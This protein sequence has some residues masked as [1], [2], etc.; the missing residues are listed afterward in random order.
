MVVD[1]S[2]TVVVP[3]SEGDGEGEETL[4]FSPHDNDNI[5]APIEAGVVPLGQAVRLEPEDLPSEHSRRFLRRRKAIQRMPYS[6]ERIKHKQLLQGYDM[7]GFESISEELKLPRPNPDLLGSFQDTKIPTDL[8]RRRNDKGHHDE[9]DVVTEPIIGPVSEDE[10]SEAEEEERQEQ[11]DEVEEEEGEEDNEEELVKFRGRL[12]NIKTGFRG[13]LPRVAWE[14]AIKQHNSTTRN[15]KR[16]RDSAS[17]NHRGVAKKKNVATEKNVNQDD[18]LLNDLIVPD[19][20]VPLDDQI[21]LPL[22]KTNQQEVHDL[23]QLDQQYQKKYDHQYLSDYED[24]VEED[25]MD[26]FIIELGEVQNKNQVEIAPTFVLTPQ[27]TFNQDDDDPD[28]MEVGAVENDEGAIDGMLSKGPRIKGQGKFKSSTKRLGDTTR[29]GS[30]RKP[31]SYRMT[32]QRRSVR[33]PNRGNQQR[34]KQQTRLPSNYLP[35]QNSLKEAESSNLKPTSTQKKHNDKAKNKKQNSETI[36]PFAPLGSTNTRRANVFST[37]MEAPSDK[38]A[39]PKHGISK[40]ESSDLII[41][42]NTN[43]D[44]REEAPLSALKSLFDEKQVIPPDTISLNLPDRQFVLS[45]FHRND[46]PL[47]LSNIFDH[48]TER[49][50]TDKELL[51]ISESVTLFL[52][53]FNHLGVLPVISEFH[54]RF[55]S[56]VSL[57]REKAKSIHFYQIAVCQLMLLEVSKYSDISNASRV[58]LNSSILNHIISF[59]KL[60]SYCYDAVAKSDP[61]YLFQSFDILSKIAKMLN[62]YDT[63]WDKL[64]EQGFRPEVCSFLIDSFHTNNPHWEILKIEQDY[65]SI[66]EAF[67]FVNHCKR[68]YNWKITKNLIF[69]FDKIFKRRRFEDFTNECALTSGYILKPSQALRNNTMF[70]NYLNLLQEIELSDLVVERI[71]PMG[72]LSPNDSVAALINRLNLLMV[73]ARGSHVNL[74]KRM[75][76]LLRPLLDSEYLSKQDHQSLKKI[77]QLVLDGILSLADINR[78]KN[79]PFRGKILVMTFKNLLF[80]CGETLE[81]AWTNFL[82]QLIP[83]IERSTK[84]KLLFC[85][86]FYPCLILMSQRDIFTENLVQVLQL[87]LRNLSL[88]GAKWAQRNILQ[89]VKNKVDLSANWIDYY[90][91]VGKFLIQSNVMSWWSFYMYNDV[92]NSLTNKFY[93]DCKILQMCD[94]QSFELIKKSM[95]T[96]A[97]NSILQISSTWFRRFLIQL[98]N[99]ECSIIIDHRYNKSSNDTLNIAKRFVW[100]LNRL[101]YNDLLLQFI[102]NLKNCHQKKVVSI[103]FVTQMLEYLNLKFID[104]IK[105]SHDFFSLKRELGISDIETEK[106]AFRDAF[107]SQKDPISQASF[108]EWGLIHAH[109]NEEEM[110]RYMDKLESLFN[111]SAPEGSFRFFIRLITVHLRGYFLHCKRRLLIYFLYL[112]NGVLNARHLQISNSEFLELCMLH[113]ILC[114]PNDVMNNAIVT[115]DPSSQKNLRAEYLQFQFNVLRIADG[116]LEFELLAQ[117]SRKFLSGS[118]WSGELLYEELFDIELSNK[119][120]DIFRYNSLTEQLDHVYIL[121]DLNEEELE[122]SISE[123]IKDTPPQ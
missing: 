95:F 4:I 68:R 65:T 40:S 106:S 62:Q 75:E 37:V 90:C 100:M 67:R 69:L 123:L 18:S 108:V 6:L 27:D 31:S 16:R 7:S 23:K 74:E 13:V 87:Y 98:M 70:N 71:I 2:G 60:L 101:S 43:E 56:K 118:P 53:H 109:S 89:V 85:K 36:G 51:Q 83:I 21:S 110:K 8:S 117:M 76:D 103:E 64:Q 121:H 5:M 107:R 22:R 34:I 120:E 33:A 104:N 99:R 3:D 115:E 111:F 94:N 93:F 42:D 17:G 88:L 24:E 122:S 81:G 25:Q 45:K 52:L 48:I 63:L 58:E 92:R 26:N 59:F 55:R 114:S 54:K 61:N 35:S 113:K 19:D 66:K 49:G 10:A 91:T 38:Y 78:I 119:I 116:F 14:K 46:T 29:P 77:G 97:T 102:S 47:V 30:T 72:E 1:D 86:E 57:L 112:I 82:D 50:V 84:S 44:L 73:L 20:E 32:P 96:T 28:L 80:E 41:L 39:L 79:L 15:F 105:D 9:E 12:I 11:E